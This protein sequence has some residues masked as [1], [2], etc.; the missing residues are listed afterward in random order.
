MAH[1]L[2]D[3]LDHMSCETPIIESEEAK[4][5]IMNKNQEMEIAYL[6]RY[7]PPDLGFTKEDLR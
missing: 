5:P 6:S 4:T 1:T 3:N 2:S 7:L